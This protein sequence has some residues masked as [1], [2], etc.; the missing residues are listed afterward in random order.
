MNLVK[1]IEQYADHLLFAFYP[2][3]QEEEL[4]CTVTGTYF[5]KF[6]EPVVL[7]IINRNQSVMGPYNMLN[8]PYHI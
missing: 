4:E 3:R 5:A 7:N 6:E 2:F 8:K 1:N